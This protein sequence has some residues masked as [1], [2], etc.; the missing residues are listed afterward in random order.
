MKFSNKMTRGAYLDLRGK[1]LAGRFI[2]MECLGLTKTKRKKTRWR[3][4]CLDCGQDVI[5]KRYT[6][7]SAVCCE[8]GPRRGRIVDY[9]D[10][11]IGHVKVLEVAG[12]NWGPRKQAVWKCVC[13]Y[14]GC[15]NIFY[16]GSGTLRNNV[17]SLT[18]GG[19]P[20]SCGCYRIQQARLVALR[21]Y[22]QCLNSQT[23]STN[24]GAKRPSP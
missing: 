21:S 3:A 12:R 2:V 15:G 11:Q 13:T 1:V 19:W 23:N 5:G 7:E 18:E 4:T 24:C 20:T 6:I 14:N 22:K 17:K 8:N 9:T 10:Q 16:R